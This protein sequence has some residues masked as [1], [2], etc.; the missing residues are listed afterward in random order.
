VAATLSSLPIPAWQKAQLQQLSAEGALSGVNPLYIGLISGAESG[1]GNPGPYNSS[2]YGGYFGTTQA[3]SGVTQPT[4]PATYDAQ[5]IAAARIF[6]A[7]L[8][9]SG[10]NAIGAENYYQTGSV[11]SSS[12]GAALF[13]EFLGGGKVVQPSSGSS[14]SSN[15]GKTSF[16]PSGTASLG[17]INLQPIVDAGF[18]GAIIIG[19]VV[20]VL[21]AALLL[22]RSGGQTIKVESPAPTGGA[23]PAQSDNVIPVDFGGTAA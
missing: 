18:S 16:T 1:W 15:S 14:S 10:G 4:S 9:A 22:T 7:G 21:A 3:E 20:L 6:A 8:R 2:G 17:P 12:N 19:A 23:P 13:A 11:G 5:A